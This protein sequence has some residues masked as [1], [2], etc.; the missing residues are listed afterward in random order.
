MP[1]PLNVT[2]H[3][4]GIKGWEFADYEKLLRQ[5]IRKNGKKLD[6]FMPVECWSKMD[7]TEMR[8]TWAAIQALPPLP[9][10]GR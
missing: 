8:A 5:G 7:D 1:I 6:P 2:L 9:F 10:G 3:E 4:T